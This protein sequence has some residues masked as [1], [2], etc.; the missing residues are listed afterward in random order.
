MHNNKNTETE[1]LFERFDNIDD[2][3]DNP[4]PKDNKDDESDDYFQSDK[5][6]TSEPDVTV[7]HQPKEKSIM[8][9]I[10]GIL[11]KVA[12]VIVA[13]AFM[14]VSVDSTANYI[15]LSKNGREVKTEIVE[16]VGKSDDWIYR[17]KYYNGSQYTEAECVSDIKRDIGETLYAF[18]IKENGV[19]KLAE[20]DNV[21]MGAYLGSLFAL[22]A[23]FLCF[24]DFSLRCAGILLFGTYSVFMGIYASQNMITGLNIVTVLFFIGTALFR[25]KTQK[26]K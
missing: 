21:D 5:P 22:I 9:K 16:Y 13:I 25:R 11:L 19:T 3:L 6:K 2:L 26:G 20:C 1:D 7:K 17:V 23:V 14:A 18:E 12:I 10:I 4:K 8:L 24:K 15:A